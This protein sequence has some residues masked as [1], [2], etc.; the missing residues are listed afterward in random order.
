[1]AQKI[2]NF[3]IY[4]LAFLMPFFFLPFSA[5]IVEFNKL[6]LLIALTALGFFAW[7]YRMLFQ[8]KTV[9]IS[10]GKAD[11][12]ILAFLILSAVSVFFAQD[13]ITAIWGENTRFW[14]SLIGILACGIFY[15]VCSNNIAVKKQNPENPESAQIK[16]AN[17]QTLFS[18][19]ISGSIILIG[20][21][22]LS[23]FG[24]LAKIAPTL[25]IFKNSPLSLPGFSPAG[26]SI[27]SLAVF[28]SFFTAFLILLITVKNKKT[29]LP[30]IALAGSSVLL[31]LISSK[32][33]WICLSLSLFL[34]LLFAFWKRIFKDNIT[35]LTLPTFLLLMAI[36][37]TF[38]NPLGLLPKNTILSQI[39]RE[40]TLNQQASWQIAFSQ[41]KDGPLFGSGIGNFSPSFS[42]YKPAYFLANPFWQ[43]RF[44]RPMSYFSEIADTE[45][46]LGFLSYLSLALVFLLGL[47]KTTT[48]A[49]ESRPLL[50]VT[51]FSFISLILIQTLYY[52]NILLAFSFWMILAIISGIILPRKKHKFSFG[53]FPEAGLILNVFFWI[54][55]VGFGFFGF[56]L[57][58]NYIASAYYKDYLKNPA[59]IASLEKSASVAK[60]QMVYQ[61]L[62]AKTYT[63]SLS[64]E[65]TIEKP[66]AKK[67]NDW[68]ILAVTSAKYALEKWPQRVEAQETA[69]FTYQAI[70]GLA[71]GAEEWSLK[72]F[73][74]ASL[75]EPKNPILLTEIAKLLFSQKDSEKARTF[76]KKAIAIKP[77]YIA[78][79][80]L[81][82]TLEEQEGNKS[83]AQD[84][85]EKTAQ[86]NTYSPEA[87][88]EL[89]K[90]YFNDN[91]T[92]KAEQAFL[93]AINLMP[94]YSNALYSLGLTYQK[95]GQIDKA[96]EYFQKVLTLNPN[97][98][99]IQKK[100]ESLSSD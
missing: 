4:A 45:G 31:I 86:A 43:I 61:L 72:S 80:T 7:I 23:I 20:L 89:G 32:I 37:F 26:Q 81:L 16:L 82:A 17:V 100:V 30:F 54:I 74:Q 10:W 24:I 55:I 34:F 92:N 50:V 75:L 90:F 53:E 71:K 40:V 11:L 19:F 25:N 14:P 46:I 1:M 59:K 65:I 87:F 57:A 35:R 22:L 93:A 85:L 9:K 28:L 99:E 98:S 67:I 41:I 68:A 42:Q 47:W 95:K 3:C 88:F 76:L 51:L 63:N 36:V 33:A 62:L 96:L 91:Q 18:S 48:Q 70:Q 52:Q 58:K 13:K 5:E 66:D 60:N 78:A 8:E 94:N 73:E 69:G 64:Q 27:E 56:S 97:N 84:L 6:Y 38:Y 44:D 12:A 21:A 79:T 49:K 2:V 83:T 29:I 77:D 15:F 39:P